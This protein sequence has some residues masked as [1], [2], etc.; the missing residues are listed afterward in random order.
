[1]L[2]SS[3]GLLLAAAVFHAVSHALIKNAR[4]QLAFS[5]WMLGVSTVVGMPILFSLSRMP[6][7]AWIIVIASGLLEAAY[8]A[9]LTRAYALGD[10]STVYPLAR[11][12]GPVFTLF[13]AFIFLGE[14]PS[15]A[16]LGGIALV[17]AGLYLVN[18]PAIA[19]WKRPLMLLRSGAT[20]WALLTGVF[21]SG[22]TS[23]DKV[24]VRYLHPIVYLYLVLAIA[25]IA[26]APQW[27]RARRRRGLIGELGRRDSDRVPVDAGTCLRIAL[28]SLFAFSAYTLVLAALRLSPASYVAPVREMSIVIGAWIG[29]RYFKE[30]GGALKIV[31]ASLIAAGIAVIVLAG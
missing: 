22:Y 5:W 26:L 20:R 14:R 12:S 11:G 30:K 18:L 7:S 23:V 17:V 16:G 27:L 28:C 3:L 4:D 29:V 2:L 25:W 10:L 31:A 19:A 21:I 24:G 6:A 8:F 1:M 9:S 13:W 15:A